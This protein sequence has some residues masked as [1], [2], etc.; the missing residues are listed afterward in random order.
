MVLEP[1][2][3]LDPS[4]VSLLVIPRKSGQY[5]LI[6]AGQVVYA[7]V[8]KDIVKSALRLRPEF[9]W[10]E[11]WTSNSQVASDVYRK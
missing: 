9:L 4:A 7:G 3:A 8:S 6:K 5:F 2:A 1:P 11:V 10:D